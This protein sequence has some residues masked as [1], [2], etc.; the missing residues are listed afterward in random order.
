M[1]QRVNQAYDGPN[2]EDDDDCQHD[3]GRRGHCKLLFIGGATVSITTIDDIAGNVGTAGTR[4]ESLSE[5][6]YSD[7]SK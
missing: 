2:N 1:R 6:R 7:V 4:R 3:H 5:P